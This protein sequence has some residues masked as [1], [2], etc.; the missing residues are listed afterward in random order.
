[1]TRTPPSHHRGGSSGTPLKAVVIIVVLVAIGAFV[2]SRTGSS[3]TTKTATSSP[4]T[5]HTKPVATSPTTAA[6]PTTTAPLVPA[7]QVKVQVLNGTGSGNLASQWSTRLHATA[8]YIT[9]PPDDATATVT[10]SVIYVLTP[11]YVPEAQALAAAVG[12]PSSAVNTTVPA[13]ASAPIKATERAA[14]NLVL[15]VGPDLASGA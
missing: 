15:V 3:G 6:A 2:L 9:E 10:Q 13:P 8:G 11:G 5:V 7:S 12:L 1:M 14:A 4:T